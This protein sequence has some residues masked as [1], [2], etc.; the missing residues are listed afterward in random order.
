M[1]HNHGEGVFLNT[2]LPVALNKEAYM[3]FIL[4]SIGP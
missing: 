4:W 1:G 3:E 2:A